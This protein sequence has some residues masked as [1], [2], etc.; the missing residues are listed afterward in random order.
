MRRSNVSSYRRPYGVGRA[1]LAL[2]V[3]ASSALVQAEATA[4]AAATTVNVTAKEFHF[5][6]SAKSVKTGKVTFKI[7][8]KGHLSHDF[9][10]D[11]VE[12]KLISPHHSTSITVNF[13]KPGSYRYM[14]TVPGHA[15]AG[16]KGKLK[17]T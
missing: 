13:K 4:H 9:K 10:I 14:C 11:G 16:M 8:N 5:T 15:A 2:S 6:L 12:S 7:T 17:V 3:V 1:A